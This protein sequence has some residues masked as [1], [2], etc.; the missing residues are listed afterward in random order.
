M[1]TKRTFNQI[2]FPKRAHGG[3]NQ[4]SMYL[5]ITIN[6]IR[7]EFTINR[8][9]D[10]KDWNVQ[11]RRMHGK[12]PKAKE[13]NSYLDAIEFRIYEIYRELV[14]NGEQIT[15]DVI[16]AKFHGVDTDKPR[17][18]LEI[19]EEHNKQFSALVGKDFS[20]GSLKRFQVVT[21]ALE[22]F[23]QWK[24]QITDISIKKLNFEFIND[25][26]FYLKSV[27]NCSHNTVMGYVKKLKKIVRQCV[28]KDWLDKDPFM[29]YKV[30]LRET[31][32]TVLTE[33]ELKI[34]TEKT[35]IGRM[36]Q[37][38][39]IF[40]FSCYTGLAYSDVEKLTAAEIS[41]GIDGE[42][43]IMTTR[44]KTDTATRVPLLPPSLAILAKY[45]GRPDL[46]H[47][48]R[49]LPVI[50]NQRMNGYLKELADQCGIQKLLTFHCA[51]HTFATTVT[52]SNGVPIE[53]VGKMLGHK[54][55]RTTQQYAKVLDRK[56]SDDMLKLR[57]KFQA[58]SKPD[59]AKES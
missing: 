20:K 27:R 7:T 50:S 37:I 28:A 57:S 41:T 6:G 44:T 30:T 9:I 36:D 26:E 54:S 32:R 13:F 12:N 55:L 38:R 33:K 19:F 48:G 8:D 3:A 52:L 23:L 42:K 29:A 58:S 53:T 56:V 39:D 5:R 17:M 31:H 59:K 45:E 16:K 34:M 40:L 2:I 22:E 25:F 21:K 24:F 18:L 46:L 49:L 1:N 51:R 47:S 35:L 43:W 14:A 15:A 11:S 4:A 10:M